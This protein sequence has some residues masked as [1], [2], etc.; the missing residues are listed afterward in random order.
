MRLVRAVLAASAALGIAGCATQPP[1]PAPVRRPPPSPVS[2]PLAPAPSAAA[3][4]AR[5]ASI[6]LVVMRAS[7]LALARSGNPAI[8]A[9]ARRMIADHQGTA[10]QLSLAGRRLNLLPS[11]A[12]PPRERQLLDQ[13][14]AAAA[15]DA[16]YLQ[17]MR[18][19]HAASF[20]LHSA[21]AARGASPTLRPVALNARDVEWRHLAWL[22]SVR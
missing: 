3:Y 8:R 12:L 16:A 20:A 7:Q 4:V 11:A 21:M 6:D 13:L 1:H 9:I 5:A 19:E 14:T 17:M 22:G 18:S 2:R 15:F 10:S